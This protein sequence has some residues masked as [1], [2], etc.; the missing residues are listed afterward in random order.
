[1]AHV[2]HCI[3]NIAKPVD[4]TL[5]NHLAVAQNIVLQEQKGPKSLIIITDTS[6]AHCLAICQL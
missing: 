2:A 3:H 1:M 6:P 5:L 4:F